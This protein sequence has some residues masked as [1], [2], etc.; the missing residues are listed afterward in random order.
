MAV[1]ASTEDALYCNSDTA[2]HH[3]AVVCGYDARGIPSQ[4]DI[5]ADIPLKDDTDVSIGA[6]S[7]VQKI[8]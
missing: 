5:S 6:F 2:T 8:C 4:W 3:N 7:F 1:I